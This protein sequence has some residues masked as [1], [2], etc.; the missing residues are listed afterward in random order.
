MNLH[1]GKST[2][3]LLAACS[4]VAILAATAPAMAAAPPP[5]CP[6]ETGTGPG[7]IPVQTIKIFNDSF[8]QIYAEFEV[9]KPSPDLWIQD[10][11]NVPDADK[12]KLYPYPTTVTNRIYINGL[13]GIPPGGSA[14]ITL[15]LYTQ[16]AATVVPTSNNQYAEWWQG[17][18]MQIFAAPK[19]SGPPKALQNYFDGT[20]PT[21]P[22]GSQAP[23][24]FEASNPTKPT[25]AAGGNLDSCT[26]TFVTDTAGTLPKF[27]P[28]QLVEATLG[29]NQGKVPKPTDGSITSFLFPTQADF[30]VSYVNVADLAAAMGPVGNDQAGYVGSPMLPGGFI[31]LLNKFQSLNTWPTFI[32][33]DGTRAAIAKLPSPLE[34]MAR[35][36]GAAAPSD[37]TPL[38]P[39]QSWP[40][41]V[42]QPIQTLRR[43]WNTYS[44]EPNC[45]HSADGYT[46]FC[47]AVLDVRDLIH[48]N[49]VKY[50]ALMEAGTCTGGA[51]SETADRTVAHVYGWQPWIEA[52]SGKEGEGCNPKANLLENTPDYGSED[53]TYAKYA[54]V[55]TEFDNLNYGGPFGVAW[56]PPAPY[57]FNPWVTFIHG[58]PPGNRDPDK[59]NLGIP[60]VYAYSVDDAVGNLN[61]YATGYIVDI[62]STEHLENQNAAGPPINI[63]LGFSIDDAVK[64][65]TYSVCGPNKEKKV[66]A[67]DPAFIISAINPQNCPVWLRDNN[68]TNYTFT[69]KPTVTTPPLFTEIPTRDVIKVPSNDARWSTGIG[70]PLSGDNPTRYDT[71]S[72]IDCS[73][74]TSKLTKLWCCTRLAPFEGKGSGSGVFAYSTPQYPPTGHTLYENK[75]VTNPATDKILAGDVCNMGR[76]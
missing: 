2:L 17:Q 63:S 33:L 29:A 32:D 49:Y 7:F 10:I 6:T 45:E 72:I 18:N 58:T 68:G 15:P 28:S 57:F 51:V 37:L 44:K 50:Q 56:Q 47:D 39:P 8:Q 42:W 61:V 19:G 70:Y 20:A 43:N 53:K 13:T 75:V 73:G 64:F 34:L 71:T 48:A 69:V 74:N 4:T 76:P 1:G 60:G 52:A 27:A 46:T 55:K 66:N 3:A 30:D 59:G 23:M 54:K 9:G 24:V 14:T 36:S 21:R 40:N 31:T 38:V 41:N 26:L 65:D 5:N 22:A 35:L 67:A 62:G 16:L 12:D 25:C 11:C